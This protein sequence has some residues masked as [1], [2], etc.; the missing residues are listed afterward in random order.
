MQGDLLTSRLVSK[1]YMLQLT[2]TVYRVVVSVS[3][4]RQFHAFGICDFPPVV[5]ANINN[6]HQYHELSPWPPAVSEVP[7]IYCTLVYVK[8]AA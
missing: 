6:N 4:H 7:D 5:P 3:W 1:T 8:T 2:V